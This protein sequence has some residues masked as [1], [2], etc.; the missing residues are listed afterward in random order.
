MPILS[1]P[2]HEKFCELVAAGAKPPEAYG[3]AGY[4]RNGA[5]QA[6]SRLLSK[7]E[8]RTRVQ[9]FQSRAQASAIEKSALSRGWVLERLKFIAERCMREEDFQPAAANR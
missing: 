9:E 1:N 4:S 8:V 2:R 5:S 6:A 3:S 7:P